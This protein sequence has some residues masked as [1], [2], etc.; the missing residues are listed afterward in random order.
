MPFTDYKYGSPFLP[1]AAIDGTN[2]LPILSALTW[3]W[4]VESGVSITKK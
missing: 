1:R 3:L 4:N 2:V